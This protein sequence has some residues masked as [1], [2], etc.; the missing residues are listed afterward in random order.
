MDPSE[1]DAKPHCASDFGDGGEETGTSYRQPSR[2]IVPVRL[3]KRRR[4]PLTSLRLTLH[5][6]KAASLA[7]HRAAAG[8]KPWL[9]C[10][11]PWMKRAMFPAST[12]LSAFL[13][14]GGSR[15]SLSNPCAAPAPGGDPPW[16]HNAIHPLTAAPEHR[17][18][19][20]RHLRSGRAQPGRSAEPGARQP[21]SITFPTRRSRGS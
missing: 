7:A 3:P 19:A 12:M 21:P 11:R 16:L 14:A 15:L 20:T 9:R 1:I 5:S 18:A 17:Q 2:F 10:R 8:A 6:P 4:P 13:A